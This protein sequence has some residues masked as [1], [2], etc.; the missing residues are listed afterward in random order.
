MHEALYVAVNVI[1][2]IPRGKPPACSISVRHSQCNI[3]IH[4][5]PVTRLFSIMLPN[6]DNHGVPTEARDIYGN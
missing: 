2:M 4:E 1:V 5:G 3:M 6:V